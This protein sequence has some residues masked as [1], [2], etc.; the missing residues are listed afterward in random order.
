MLNRIARDVIDALRGQHR[1]FEFML[2][3]KPV[4]RIYNSGRKRA[5]TTDGNVSA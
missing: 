2:R 4:T 1:E 5:R 3:G